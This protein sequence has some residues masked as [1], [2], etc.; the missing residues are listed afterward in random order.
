MWRERDRYAGVPIDASGELPDGTPIT[1]PDD[2]R[3]ALLRRPE[4][5]VQTFTEGLLTYATGRTLRR[6]TCRPCAG[7]SA[8][9]P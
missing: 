9:Q 8:T 2:L 1:S 6:P 4:Q 7:S 3:A 5:F